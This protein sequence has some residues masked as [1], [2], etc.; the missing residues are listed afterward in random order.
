MN[1]KQRRAFKKTQIEKIED[2]LFTLE[3]SI[4]TIVQNLDKEKLKSASLQML[5]AIRTDIHRIETRI[6]LINK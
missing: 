4:N 5:K 3:T 2:E 1:S 6:N